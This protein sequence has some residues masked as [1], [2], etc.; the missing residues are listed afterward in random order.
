M[1]L[2]EFYGPE[3]P[4]RP[5]VAKFGSYLATFGHVIFWVELGKKLKGVSG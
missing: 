5:N 3:R 4:L 1:K 2:R